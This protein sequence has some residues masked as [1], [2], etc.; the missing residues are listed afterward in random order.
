MRELEE[1][2]DI[3][4]KST[5]VV[6]VEVQKRLNDDVLYVHVNGITILRMC[7]INPN[8]FTFTREPT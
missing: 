4:G 5:D 8:N 6:Q 1:T 7:R 3:T 2:L